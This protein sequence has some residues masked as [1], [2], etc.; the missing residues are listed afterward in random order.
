MA[1]GHLTKAPATITYVSVV[2][3]ETVHLA[4]TFASLN[5][6]KVKVGDVLNAY[7]TAPVKEK[8]W[9]I[10]GPKFGLDS[11]KSA[12]IVHALYGLKSA[13]AVFQAHLASFMRQMGYT[14]CK[15]DPDLW[16]KAVTRPEVNVCCYAYIICYVDD[17]LCIHHDPMSVMGEINKYL[18]LKP[19]SVRDPD[20]Y[21]GAKLKETRLPNGVMA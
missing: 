14:S 18:P 11:G 3:R 16:L 8:V 17:I 13:G 10:L 12:V 19:S 5:D 4:L 6:L 21:L 20:I 1:G 15:A 9:T 2:S 7:I